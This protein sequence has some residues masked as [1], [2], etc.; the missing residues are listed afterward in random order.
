MD[1]TA[2]TD[3]GFSFCRAIEDSAQLRCHEAMGQALYSLYADEAGRREACEASRTEELALAC[4]R[5][6]LVRTD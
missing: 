6:A 4:R 3:A 1:V 5:G 2:T